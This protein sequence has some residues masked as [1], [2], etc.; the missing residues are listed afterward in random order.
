MYFCNPLNV[1]YKKYYF[2]EPEQPLTVVSV[3]E[4]LAR[5]ENLYIQLLQKS[6]NL[7]LDEKEMLERKYGSFS[8][9]IRRHVLPSG[10]TVHGKLHLR[11][12]SRD[13]LHSI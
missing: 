4:N 3:L 13:I 9:S 7:S 1:F 5:M 6:N 8:D 12:L 11:Q 10:S 2:A